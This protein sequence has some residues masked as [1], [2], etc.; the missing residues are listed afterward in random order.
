MEWTGAW[1][2]EQ[3]ACGWVTRWEGRE[4]RS[5]RGEAA[6]GRRHSP[7]PKKVPAPGRAETARPTRGRPDWRAIDRAGSRRRCWAAPFRAMLRS[8]RRRGQ[9]TADSE[10]PTR[11]RS[12]AGKARQRCIRGR[13]TVRQR[14]LSTRRG[15]RQAEQAR[16]TDAAAA[17]SVDAL[18]SLLSHLHSCDFIITQVCAVW[19]C[20][21][22]QKCGAIAR[23]RRGGKRRV[24][25]GRRG[26]R[27]RGGGGDHRSGPDGGRWHVAGV[28]VRR[29]SSAQSERLPRWRAHPAPPR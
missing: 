26:E 2:A 22:T 24:T 8:G 28:A 7:P 15:A 11:R 29:P 16:E 14:S 10:P 23:R 1:A 4:R 20:F 18:P 27:S 12:R 6:Y 21:F 5:G 25:A 3:S 19:Q 17:A 13:G 9:A